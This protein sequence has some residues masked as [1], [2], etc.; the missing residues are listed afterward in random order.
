M[1]QPSKRPTNET[2]HFYDMGIQVGSLK[3]NEM[4]VSADLDADVRH[5]KVVYL[6]RQ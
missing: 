5:V 1:H 3:R 6:T 4:C 2:N